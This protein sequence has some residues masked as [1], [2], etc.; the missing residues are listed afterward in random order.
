MKVNTT[1]CVEWFGSGRILLNS[2]THW[3]NTGIEPMLQK[4]LIKIP[5]TVQ[6]GDLLRVINAGNTTK[7]HLHGDLFVKVKL[8]NLKKLS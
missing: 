7:D 1:P 4:L 3:N 8:E 2:W 6:E 5:A